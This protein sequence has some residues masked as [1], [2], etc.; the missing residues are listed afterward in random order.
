MITAYDVGQ[1][2]RLPAV[3]IGIDIE[4]DGSIG[5]SVRLKVRAENDEESYYY[6]DQ[7]KEAG[8]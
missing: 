4:E 2:I 3:V 8:V 6:E 7:L 5:Y 1:T